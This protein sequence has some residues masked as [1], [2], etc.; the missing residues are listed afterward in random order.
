MFFGF[1]VKVYFWLSDAFP[2]RYNKTA[3]IPLDIPQ[4][5]QIVQSCIL[6]VCKHD[7]SR[8]FN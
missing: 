5:W 8:L 7:G 3:S 1:I 2:T 4:I 6:R